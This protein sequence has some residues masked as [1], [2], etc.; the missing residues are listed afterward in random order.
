M[1]N[2]TLG[3][4]LPQN[5][6]NGALSSLK[7][8]RLLKTAL[9]QGSHRVEWVARRGDGVDVPVEVSTT[10]I[11]L[12]GKALLFACF[13]ISARGRKQRVRFFLPK[14]ILK[15]KVRERTSDL[16]AANKRLAREGRRPK[17]DRTKMRMS[18]EELRRLSEHLHQMGEEGKAHVAREVHDQ[19]GQSL[20]AVRIDLACLREQVAGKDENLTRQ[21]E[22]IESQI[23][24][25]MQSVREIC[26]ELRPPVLDDFGVVTALKWHIREFEKKT[27]ID[28]VLMIDDEISDSPQRAWSRNFPSI[29]GGDDEYPEAR[30]RH[31]GRGGAKNIRRII[32]YSRSRIMEKV[33]L[34][35]KLRTPYP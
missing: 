18:R 31:Q 4:L 6:H 15:N 19:L 8:D 13:G 25:A 3:E 32:L 21:V 11:V 29:P 30:K 34:R 20:S 9:K 33:S 35:T 12:E 2:A 14:Q 26:R 24:D 23:G 28:C 1:L 16:V 5:W 10:V 17:K 7:A 22:E 27:G